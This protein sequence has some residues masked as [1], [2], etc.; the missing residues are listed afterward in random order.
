M[1][2]GPQGW[3]PLHGRNDDSFKHRP[4]TAAE[5]FEIAVGA[6]LTQNTSWRNVEK[7]LASLRSARALSRKRILEMEDEVLQG[8]I[9]PAGYFRQK[10]RKLKILAAHQGPWTRDALLGLW[11]IGPETADSIL[12]YALDVPTFVVDTY[13]RRLLQRKGIICGKESYNDIQELFHSSL[14]KDAKL[15]NEFH[16]LI[17][18]EGKLR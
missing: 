13:T 11:G 2:H 10:A 7:A 16:A 15:F 18:A 17:V 5:R 12:L 6:V 3:W 4:K 9:R 14:P 8:I 1:R